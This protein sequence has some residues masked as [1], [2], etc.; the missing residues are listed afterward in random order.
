[1]G[2][3]QE[4]PGIA[5]MHPHWA[6]AMNGGTIPFV[7]APDLEVATLG[8][9]GFDCAPSIN[10][11]RKDGLVKLRAKGLEH[12]YPYCGSGSLR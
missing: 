5:A 11:S 2:I 10:L 4:L 6:R 12:Y 1:M 9:G 3:G 7:D 8:R